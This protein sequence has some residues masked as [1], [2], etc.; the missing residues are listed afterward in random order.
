MKRLL[1]VPSVGLT[2]LFATASLHAAPL[3][4]EALTTQLTASVSEQALVITPDSS[5]P[6][7]LNSPDA[8]TGNFYSPSLAAL[9]SPST[10][11]TF[12]TEYQPVNGSDE[13][14]LNM[15]GADTLL[16]SDLMTW[17]VEYVGL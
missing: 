4:S 8:L 15:S 11:R 16:L 1:Y 7:S 14:T 17:K 10:L 5:S 3:P 12:V 13:F 2:L 9:D 6:L